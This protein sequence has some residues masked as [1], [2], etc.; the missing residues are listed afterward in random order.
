[1]ADEDLGSLTGGLQDPETSTEAEESGAPPAP[2]FAT[3]APQPCNQ[4]TM[5][6]L[7]GPCVHLWQL[8]LRFPSAV[9]DV[10]T[11]HVWTCLAGPEEFELNEK[12]V[13]FCDRWWPRALLR[14]DEG[15]VLVDPDIFEQ[16]APTLEA[17]R[18][19]GRP[20]L[21]AAWEDALALGLGY[22]FSWRDFDPTANADDAPD[23]R[24][25]SGPGGFGAAREAAAA[26]ELPPAGNI[27][28][29]EEGDPQ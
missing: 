12:L 1:M 27:P 29:F 7:R 21:H 6:C 9:K 10:M 16:P 18:N 17:S 3:E 5:M 15:R 4:A 28:D 13:Y 23:Q 20:Q 11:E 22:D 8:A 14:D 19:R 24:A 2:S 26:A 25:H